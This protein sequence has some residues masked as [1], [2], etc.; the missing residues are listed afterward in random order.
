MPQYL[1]VDQSSP[2]YRKIH[3]W[4]LVCLSFICKGN[5]YTY[6]SIP[7]CKPCQWDNIPDQNFTVSHF[8]FLETF[9]YYILFCVQTS[10]VNCSVNAKLRFFYIISLSLQFPSHNISQYF[11]STS[12]KLL[13]IMRQLI[14]LKYFSKVSTWYFS[15]KI[16]F[17]CF[18]L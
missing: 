2:L 12:A 15:I 17:S 13:L 18:D 11:L 6:K 1:F 10:D 3:V 16:S 7:L 4:F 14:Y 5:I 8:L 9:C